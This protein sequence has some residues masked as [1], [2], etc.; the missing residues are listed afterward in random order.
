MDEAQSK[1]V[2]DLLV[3]EGKVSEDDLF[4]ALERCPTEE[5]KRCTDVIHNL[6]CKENHGSEDEDPECEYWNEDQMDACWN[7]EDHISW[8]KKTRKLMDEL[9]IAS[10]SKL[11]AAVAA[12]RA[13]IEKAEK[14]DHGVDLLSLILSH[15]S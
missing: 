5:M 14:T 12:A 3:E 1:A 10:E 11:N 6:L 4:E 8:L 7:R 13:A 15:M 9:N 2:L